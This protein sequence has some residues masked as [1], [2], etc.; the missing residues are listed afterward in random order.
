[1]GTIA[2]THASHCFSDDFLGFFVGDRLATGIHL[3]KILP[4]LVRDLQLPLARN[5][6]GLESTNTDRFA[7]MDAASQERFDSGLLVGRKIFGITN[8]G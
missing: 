7:F 4:Q 2:G 3:G 1:M 6:E 8:D 5:A